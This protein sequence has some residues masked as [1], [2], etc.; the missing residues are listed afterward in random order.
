MGLENHQNDN[1]PNAELI[2]RW[3]KI[4]SRALADSQNVHEPWDCPLCR[5]EVNKIKSAGLKMKGLA[6]YHCAQSLK[7]G[8]HDPMPNEPKH[9]SKPQSLELRLVRLL[10]GL[11]FERLCRRVRFLK[12]H[13]LAKLGRES[14]LAD[15]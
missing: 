14:L 9:S 7:G 1:P 6:Y 3:G 15:H 10:S 5:N 2:D 4:A 13:V 12:N 11:L 8:A